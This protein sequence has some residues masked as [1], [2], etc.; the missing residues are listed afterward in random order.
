MNRPAIRWDA[1]SAA[2]FAAELCESLDNVEKAVAKNYVDA[3]EDDATAKAWGVW[4]QPPDTESGRREGQY[5]I[6]GT[7]AGLEL[8]ASSR[9][10]RND[11]AQPERRQLIID[12]WRYL[13]D[14]LKVPQG[15]GQHR[16]GGFDRSEDYRR[17]LAVRQ[18]QVLRCLSAL[19]HHITA[20]SRETAVPL[21]AERNRE[22]ADQI[23]NE[24]AL[25]RCADQ[26]I[27]D[28]PYLADLEGVTVTLYRFSSQ[29]DVG[30]D[31]NK[32]TLPKA[33]IEWAYL[34]GSVL[35]GLTRSYLSYFLTA[36]KFNEL[37]K[38]NELDQLAGWVTEVSTR[39]DEP[40]ELRVG[41]FVGWA[42]L[43]LEELFEEEPDRYLANLHT[44]G[45]GTIVDDRHHLK[46]RPSAKRRKAL[47]H[48]LRKG[49]TEVIHNAALRG[50]LHHPYSFHI[51]VNGKD[52]FDKFKQ[53]HLVVPTLPI[54]LW[55]KARLDRKAL[56]DRDFVSCTREVAQAFH[57]VESNEWRGV[58]PAQ[59][60]TFNGTVNMNYIHE[61]LAEVHDLALRTRKQPGIWRLLARL[62]S[63]RS[64][65][66]SKLKSPKFALVYGTLLLLVGP[67]L[68]LAYTHIGVG[69][70]TYGG[71]D[72]PAVEAEPHLTAHGKPSDVV[73]CPTGD[74]KQAASAPASQSGKS[75]RQKGC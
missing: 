62:R 30:T 18:S 43:Q 58:A 40:D 65:F 53:D 72:E 23:L 37:V 32:G 61:A 42:I 1:R 12:S 11:I 33:P 24:L 73:A 71:S 5:G 20:L 39:T 15:R 56:F 34:W 8:L 51:E 6:L 44:G 28:L 66:S 19:D 75:G 48:A 16:T 70:V 36:E 59:S 74:R 35:V 7:S 49:A 45:T 41:L 67:F 21:S 25:C 57:H 2:N 3:V 55:L 4:V 26:P 64:W 54:A 46:A 9:D 50:D 14:R 60:S 47:R 68:A 22:L 27:S 13:H 63:W 69:E 38:P 52:S 31:E 17:T 10:F 29:L